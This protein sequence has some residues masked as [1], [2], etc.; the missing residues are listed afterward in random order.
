M[1]YLYV[2]DSTE[3]GRLT[4]QSYYAQQQSQGV[5]TSQTFD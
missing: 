5:A 4:L 1:L 3:D 2:R